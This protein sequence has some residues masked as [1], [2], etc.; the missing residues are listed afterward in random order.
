[1]SGTK[2]ICGETVKNAE[3]I[4]KRTKN[5]YGETVRDVEKIGKSTLGKKD[6]KVVRNESIDLENIFTKL[7]E[8]A[9]SFSKDPPSPPNLCTDTSVV[10]TF[11]VGLDEDDNEV[12][13][14]LKEFLSTS[15]E[16][17]ISPNVHGNRLAIFLQKRR[18][19]QPQ[20]I[21]CLDF[22]DIVKPFLT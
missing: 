20:M 10:Q 14:I 9:S 12:L 11:R 3:K 18:M 17:S 13:E 16:T 2:H 22:F 15:D 19:L 5:I 8:E 21:V 7:A 6:H 4:G 1:M